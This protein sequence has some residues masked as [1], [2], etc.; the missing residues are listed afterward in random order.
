MGAW[1]SVTWVAALGALGALAA[2]ASTGPPDAAA[3]LRAYFRFSESQLAEVRR[4]RPVSIGLQGSMDREIVVGGAV[5]IETPPE[6]LLDVFRDIERLE[7]GKGFLTTRR[8]G[9]PPRLEDFASL[10]LPQDDLDDLR[11]CHPG[12]CDIKLG[13]R[14]RDRLAQID[15]RSPGAVAEAQQ[16]MRRYLFD[17]LVTYRLAGN[18]GLPAMIE[19]KGPRDVAAEFV[20]MLESAPWLKTATMAAVR[21]YLIG[22]PK[23]HRPEGLDEFFYWSFVEFG[24]KTVLRL[25]HVV[26]YP[27]GGGGPAR[28]VIAN[29]QIYATHYFQN[30]IEV[31]LLM[32]DEAAPGRAHYLLVMNIARP[33]GV[34]GLFGGL[35]RYKVRSGSRDA[36]RKTMLITKN[37]SE[38]RASGR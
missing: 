35:V 16:L 19:E 22:Y 8:I 37:R 20:E 21:E 29:R 24:L 36:L 23:A 27:L 26:I 3:I 4:G 30:A 34:T 1:R 25:N 28:Y 13:Q 32:D 15:W 11:H 5:R 10:V 31:R 14:G 7:S 38:R 2:A 9:N 12:D 6:R 33:D 17:I 18:A